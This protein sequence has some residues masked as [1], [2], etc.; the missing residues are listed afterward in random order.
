MT[1]QRLK[2][3]GGLVRTL[4]ELLGMRSA[5]VS[6]RESLEEAL[7]EHEEEALGQ[8]LGQEEREM[9]F[10]VLEYGA[11]RAY[12]VMVPRADIVGVSVD[13]TYDDLIRLF[14]NAA[15]SRMP[16]YRDTLD[17]VLGM[18]HVK[19][20]LKVMADGTDTAAFKIGAIQRPVLY[21]APS[22]KIIDLLAKMRATRTHMAI[23]VDEYGGTDGLVTVED[24]VEEIVG[25]I[26]DEHDTIEEPDLVALPGGGFDAD[27]RLEMEELEEVLGIDLLPEGE[28]EDVDTLGGLVF[29]LAGCV[30]EIGEVIVHDSGYRFEVVD[31]D[32]RRIY[33][34]R[35]HPP[36]K[37]QPAADD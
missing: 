8:T 13:T 7:D 2:N 4:K 6:L 18:V 14:A 30:P 20:A 24:I 5:E 25:E 12:D 31:A 36:V 11:L 37:D 23:V 32:P 22:M 17:D 35:I 15:H 10:N 34:V 28:R 19:D 21:V 1:E 27:A 29:S 16:V 26:E 33:K 3:Q 9:I